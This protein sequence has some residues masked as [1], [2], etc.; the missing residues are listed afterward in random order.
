MPCWW[1]CAVIQAALDGASLSG[2]GQAQI[3][4]IQRARVLAGAVEVIYEQGAADV[5]IA[6]VV[7]RAGV[8][9]RTFYQLFA[10]R[11]ECFAAAFDDALERAT[12][13]VLAAVRVERRWLERLRAGVA[14]LMCFID[15]EPRLAS[16]LLCESL[17]GGRALADR[18]ARVV[19][20]LIAFV[21]E[22]RERS[23][24]KE[25][26]PPMQAEGSVGGVLSILQNLLAS[27][28]P[29]NFTELSGS[30]VA[31]IAMPY[32][33]RAAARRELERPAPAREPSAQV[34]AL[35]G[36]SLKEAGMRL[37]YRTTRVL[38]AIAEHPDASNRRI[39][40]FAEIGDQGQTSKLLRRLQRAGLI[41]N[42]G[43][44]PG[45]G[46]P[47]VWR[48]TPAGEKLADGLRAYAG[49]SSAEERAEVREVSSRARQRRRGSAT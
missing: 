10:D 24:P 42:E 20:R 16:L 7:M 18:R 27:G 19:S 28:Q 31:M 38:L 41:V 5:A 11:E 33:G 1:W 6:D 29:V 14:A 30:F 35:P 25:Q 21:D 12:S 37:T 47:N 36:L 13:T 26:V 3:A 9:R 17:A 45:Q 48:L 46:A 15:E 40:E 44:A 34:H 4:Q 23:R 32:L 43:S 39:G 49:T 22:G 8:S 2:F